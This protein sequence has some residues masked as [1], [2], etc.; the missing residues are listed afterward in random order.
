MKGVMLNDSSLTWSVIGRMKE[1]TNMKVL[2]KGIEVGADAAL[3]VQHGA[4]GI[5][6]SNH[7]GRAVETERATI[8][9][10]PEIVAAVNGRI[11]IIVD[12][13]FRRGT[14]IYKALSLGATAVGIGRPYCWGLGAFGQAGVERVLNLLNREL[15]IAM[16]GSG[17][18]TIASIGPDYVLD[19]GHRVERGRM[20][21]GLLD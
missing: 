21:F 8:E 20:G 7:G 4:D 11:P 17:T 1:V 2:I 15:T 14:D 6:V 19:V 10:L 9:C 12:G 16:M 18:P 13:G 3:A 5:V